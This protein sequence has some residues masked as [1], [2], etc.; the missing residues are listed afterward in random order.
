MLEE[1]QLSNKKPKDI[2]I[3]LRRRGIEKTSDGRIILY[4]AT[5]A[6]KLLKILKTGKILPS[7]DTGE[8]NWSLVREEADQ[9]KN[10][11][12]YLGS[13]DFVEN[14][15]PASGILEK[16]GGRAFILEVQVDMEDLKPDEDTGAND[17]VDSL[18]YLGSCAYKG[19]IN[20]FKLVAISE[21][22]LPKDSGLELFASDLSDEEF[23]NEVTRRQTKI[24]EQENQMFKDADVDILKLS[25]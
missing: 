22:K 10:S 14:K 6:D 23:H 5:T 2:D 11:K 8:S 7:R 21:A 18:D 17:W 13:R 19:D 3:V 1:P 20:Q 12:I 25:L 9:E 4:H 16:N 24:I 15:G